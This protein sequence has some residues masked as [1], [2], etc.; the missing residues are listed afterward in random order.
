MGSLN[1]LESRGDS[2][3]TS[4]F[5]CSISEGPT[6]SENLDRERAAL[7]THD[8]AR[9]V[10]AELSDR[11]LEAVTA[12]KSNTPE[13]QAALAASG[14]LAAG[15]DSWTSWDAFK[16]YRYEFWSQYGLGFGG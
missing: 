6:M 4:E 16:Q 15:S 13:G 9:S 5:N 7:L 11:D 12:G 14:G 2:I 10:A 8:Q 3:P 1:L